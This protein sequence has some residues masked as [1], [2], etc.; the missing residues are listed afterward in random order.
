MPTLSPPELQ[1]RAI[2]RSDYHY[3]VSV[4]DRWWGGPGGQRIDPLFF[5]ELGDD[6]LVAERDGEVIGFLLGL[7][8]PRGPRLGY[9]HL[10][11]IHPDHRRR[12]VGRELYERFAERCRRAGATKLKALGAKGHEGSIRFHEAVGFHAREAPDYAGPGRTRIVFERDL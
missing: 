6:A 3:L 9:V 12:G 2:T 4:L 11:G 5:Y 8:T 7:V 10:V 1:I